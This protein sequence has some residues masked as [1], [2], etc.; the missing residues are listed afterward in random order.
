MHLNVMRCPVYVQEY[1]NPD[2]FAVRT[3]A[4]TSLDA[5]VR[6][7]AHQL[8]REYLRGAWKRITAQDIVIRKVRYVSARHIIHY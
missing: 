6:E 2:E 1:S 5:D 7:R 3:T 8:C 4:L